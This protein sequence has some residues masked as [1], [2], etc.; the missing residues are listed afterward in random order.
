MSFKRFMP[1]NI[2]LLLKNRVPFSQRRCSSAAGS[3]VCV[4]HGATM[5]GAGHLVLAR[6]KEVQSPELLLP[7]TS[8]F[9]PHFAPAEEL[10]WAA[11]ENS[12]VGSKRSVWDIHTALH[13]S[14]LRSCG[15]T[16]GS[17]FRVSPG[18]ECVHHLHI[19]DGW[20]HGYLTLEGQAWSSLER[21]GTGA[22]VLKSPCLLSLTVF[23]LPTNKSPWTPSGH[24]IVPPVLVI[25]PF[26][27]IFKLTCWADGWIAEKSFPGMHASTHPTAVL[28]WKFS[29]GWCW[30]LLSLHF[31]LPVLSV[32]FHLGIRRRWLFGL[33]MH[34][35]PVGIRPKDKSCDKNNNCNDNNTLLTVECNEMMSTP[36]HS[37]D[38]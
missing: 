30:V 37:V 26:P 16:L 5:T 11:A 3:E 29:A 7:N 10:L 4:P 6:K 33:T 35:R 17:I 27:L 2:H 25:L 28:V 21:G 9:S 38:S 32:S 20:H 18:A 14:S 1:M 36:K 31:P 22:T 13:S 34:Q 24:P 23:A 12:A 15:L 19:I 8:P